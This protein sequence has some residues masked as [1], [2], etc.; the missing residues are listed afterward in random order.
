MKI[1]QNKVVS[2][3]YTL[4]VDGETI[5]TV[6]P[7]KPM[8]FIF[9]AGYLLPK[10]EENIAG[11]AVGDI[12][13]F[14]LSAVDGYG[15]IDPEALVELPK[16]IFEVDGFIEEGLLTVGNV[17]PMSDN[18]GNRINGSV[19]E[20]LDEIV[21]MDFNHPLAGEKLHFSGAVV[22]VRD[23]TEEEINYGLRGAAGACGGDCSSGCNSCQ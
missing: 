2:L 14:E 16:N 19:A 15:E 5:E 22:A 18:G 20:V 4:V 7:E 12:F 9:G 11:K 8:Q 3:S 10:F 6:K 23:A 17:I 1:A 13:E 21:V